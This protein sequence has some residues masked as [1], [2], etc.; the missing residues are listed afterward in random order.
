M[1]CFAKL[2]QMCIDHMQQGQD[3]ERAGLWN[4]PPNIPQIPVFINPSRGLNEKPYTFGSQF[5]EIRPS[6]PPFIFQSWL[7]FILGGGETRK[8]FTS[9]KGYH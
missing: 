1:V 7:S 8:I 6:S 9:Q 3:T 4:L 5:T 2:V